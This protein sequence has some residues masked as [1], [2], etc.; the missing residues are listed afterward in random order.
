VKTLL[1]AVLTAGCAAFVPG[2]GHA[3]APVGVTA[4]CGA[5]STDD[6]TGTIANP[7]TQVGVIFGG[8]MVV[9]DLPDVDDTTTPPTVNFDTTGN[10]ASATIT[11]ALQVGGTGTYAE[12]DAVSASA[13]GTGVVDLLPTLIS[14]QAGSTDP[15]WGCTTLTLTDANGDSDTVYLD[16]ATGEYS[17]DPT[18]AACKLGFAVQV[19]PQEL[20]DAAPVVCDLPAARRYPGS[21][22][23][24][25]VLPNGSTVTKEIP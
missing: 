25:V 10:P 8:P 24:T 13:S 16:D 18:T 1:A 7:G 12:A 5:I 14:Y 22:T 11:C 23:V 3:D 6:P 19:P 2:V 17:T 20:C 4:T 15:V 21:T 9:A